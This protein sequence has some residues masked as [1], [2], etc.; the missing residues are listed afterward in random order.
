[1]SHELLEQL[2]R[3]TLASSGAIVAVMLARR[4]VGRLLGPATSYALWLAVPA[5]IVAALIPHAQG[6]APV[7]IVPV[8]RDFA[9]SH[10]VALPDAAAPGTSP[11]GTIDP[12]AWILCVWAAG[13]ALFFAYLLV[14]QRTFVRSL[15]T[16]SSAR[17]VLR[18]QH[19][20]GGPVLLGVLRPRIVLPADFESRYT[21]HERRLVLAHE[22]RHL[23]Q[24]DA[25][26][27]ALVAGMR[28]LFWFNPLVH[29]ASGCFRVDQELA[30]DSA[31]MRDHAG[32]RRTYAG[33]LLK[34]A[35]ADAALPAGCSWC[36]A[37]H[38]Q[39]RI[40]MLQQPAPGR[41]RRACGHGLI[42]LASSI[43]AY[44]AWAAQPAP[45]PPAAAGPTSPGASP[46]RQ[47][48]SMDHDVLYGGE[49]LSLEVDGRHLLLRGE[50]MFIL[51]YTAD[52]GVLELP[53]DFAPGMPRMLAVPASWTLRGHV[54]ITVNL[55]SRVGA[56]TDVTLIDRSGTGLK[57]QTVPPN[58]LIIVQADHATL[59]QSQNALGAT[60]ASGCAVTV[61]DRAERRLLSLSGATCRMEGKPLASL[62]SAP[63]RPEPGR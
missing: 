39:Q 30:C 50:T 16:L 57:T 55:G 13:V 62:A 26:W 23:R 24:G 41:T 46:G 63:V 29:L 40:R 31:V 20:A 11:T 43:A 12:A 45:A 51:Q 35:L 44:A 60:F 15:G 14:L 47:M 6:A 19:A 8:V 56:A 32:A 4:P 22:R 42:A 52:N 58:A 27:N 17:G 38:L 48:I 61:M 34:A 25:L 10:A 5:S 37:G 53:A 1:M 54:R 59:S 33:A 49:P 21:R 28:G 7:L 9:V 3:L 36:S 18:A 2:L